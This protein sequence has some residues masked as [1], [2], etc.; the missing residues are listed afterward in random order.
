MTLKPAGHFAY[1]AKGLVEHRRLRKDS[2]TVELAFSPAGADGH[3]LRV[4]LPSWAVDT[5]A[6][7]V[8]GWGRASTTVDDVRSGHKED[9]GQVAPRPKKRPTNSSRFAAAARRL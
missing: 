4:R 9:P 3:K 8:M 7:E 2:T 5:L 1:A 6:L